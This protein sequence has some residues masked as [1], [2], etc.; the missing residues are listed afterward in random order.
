[1]KIK[2]IFILFIFSIGYIQAQEYTRQDSLRGKLSP[3]RT[4]FDVKFY[5]LQVRVNPETKFI[6]GYNAI[7]YQVVEDFDKLQIDLFENMQIEKIVHSGKELKYKREGNATFIDFAEKQKKGTKSFFTVYYSG[8]PRVAVNA[9]WDGGF[10][11]SKDQQG[12]TWIGVSCEGLGA[13]VWFPNKDHLSDEPDSMRIACEVPSDLICVANGNL[14]KETKLEDKYTRYDWFVSYPINNYNVTLNI[15]KYAHFADTYTA[16]DGEKLALDYYVLPYNLEK[17]KKQFEQVKPMLACYEKYFGKYPF[18]KDGLALVETPYLGME[19]QSAVAY[20]NQYKQGYL[21]MDISGTGI[22]LNFDYII[23]H[24]LGHEYWGNSVSCKDHAEL[25]IHESFCTYTEALYVECLYGK[26]KAETYIYGYRNGIS[27]DKP[28]VADFDVN[29]ETSGDIYP[30]GA[31]FLHT[32]RNVVGSDKLWFEI[33]YGISQ[34]FKIKNT[35]TQELMQY[36]SKK[37]KM[38]MKNIFTQYLM[39]PDVPTFQYKITDKTLEYKWLASHQG[40][41]MPIKIIADG[42]E[43]LLKPTT[44]WQKLKLN[45]NK[46]EIKFK[47]KD[48]YVFYEKL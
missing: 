7:H 42:K 22:G 15:A 26:E 36:I 24:E 12:N 8:N 27:N 45:S 38:D 2:L 21:G 32:L 43:I 4:C 19:H 23:I 35:D 5:D 37:S 39:K 34:D 41:D 1:M 3:L 10:S 44:T 14:R 31:N 6:K 46:D 16:Q 48:Y 18:W 11:W 30:K 29:A 9:P 13:S 17:A 28:M 25:W 47:E 40:F 20:G 33:L